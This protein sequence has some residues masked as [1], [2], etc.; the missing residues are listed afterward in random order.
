MNW[1]FLFKGWVGR[2]GSRSFLKMIL[3][4]FFVSL[5]LRIYIGRGGKEGFLTG[6]FFEFGEIGG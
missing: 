3:F 1:I 6:G 2:V 5:S 4:F